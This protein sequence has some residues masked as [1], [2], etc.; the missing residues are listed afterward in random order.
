MC[1]RWLMVCIAIAALIVLPAV[2]DEEQAPKLVSITAQDTP[3]AEVAASISEQAGVQ[4]VTTERTVATITG[5][6][7]DMEVEQAVAALAQAIPGSYLR[8]YLLEKAAPEKPYTADQLIQALRDVREWW[9][10]S[11]SEEERQALFAHWRELWQQRRQQ[12]EAAAGAGQEGAP[13][14]GGP[15]APAQGPGQGATPGAG[16]PPGPGGPGEGRWLEDPLRGLALP[17]RHETISLDLQEATPE[18]MLAAFISASGYLLL[19]DPQ[20]TGTVTLSVQDAPL[21]EVLK[22]IATSLGGQWRPFYIVSQPYE[23]T[24]EERE[25]RIQARFNQRWAEYWAKSPEERAADLQERI[26]R[27]EGLIQRIQQGEAPGR[28]ARRLPGMLRRTNEYALTL[29]AE[30]RLE[31]KPYLQ[32]LARAA[33]AVGQ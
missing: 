11:M 23:L 14:A 6:I 26:A 27:L 24:E 5:E 17:E 13:P 16:G 28:M 20:L 7:R 33:N 29:T 25:Q 10:Q 2:A 22:Q 12:Q 9:L 21:A 18:Q 3:A 1:T 8:A 30:Q 4:V 19:V 32:A 31:I 15:P